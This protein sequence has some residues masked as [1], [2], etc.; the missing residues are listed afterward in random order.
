M[1]IYNEKDWPNFAW[2]AN[3]IMPLLSEV[4]H[5]Q[6]LL[7]G[8]LGAMGFPFQDVASLE[9]LT[10]DVIKS[11]EIEG[12]MLDKA[13]VRSS[14]ARCLGLDMPGMVVSS[15]DVDGMVEMLVDATREYKKPL[16]RE[17]LFGWHSSM[18]PTGRSGILRIRVGAWRNDKNGPMQVVSGPL[19][20]ER[21]HYQAPEASHLSAEM[22]A[23]LA[24]FN[25]CKNM[26]P[27]LKAGVA[28]FWFVT[29]HPF[30]DGNGRVAR[31]L[32]DML[33]ARA[34]GM[35]QRFYSMSA[36]IRLE[37]KRY[38]EVLEFSQHGELDITH[39]LVW[40]LECLARA[41]K[42]SD[43]VVGKVVRKHS[44][45][46]QHSHAKLNERQRMMLGKLAEGFEGLLT[47]VKWAK[48][49]HC[50]PDSALRDI[51]ALIEM[52]ILKKDA[53]GS[54]STSYSVV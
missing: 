16:S 29:L 44:L 6:G 23:F 42:S 25:G 54:R 13:Q 21:L 39:W 48:I 53:A 11:S 4:R 49:T 46:E 17:R 33:L 19:G 9:A 31:A 7:V 51:Q 30:E 43:G 14:L 1:Y 22:R 8:K 3:R 37:R 5:M 47:T 40:F 32:T 10:L 34:D 36:Q 18:F 50:S 35:P 52:G 45:F 15:R 27:V 41:I 28:H 12:E 20:R 24:W 26:D 2:D 38:Y